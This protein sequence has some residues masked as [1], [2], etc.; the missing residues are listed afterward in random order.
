MLTVLQR[1][2]VLAGVIAAGAATGALAQED[3]TDP[4]HPEGGTA[5]T[6][7]SGAPGDMAQNDQG[8][9]PASSGMMPSGTMGA[10]MMGGMMSSG[11]MG[12]GMMGSMMQPGAMD[13]PPMMRMHR[14]M[15][16]IVFAI[17]DEDGDGAL[18]F[19]EISAIHRRI[20]DAVDADED[21]TVT[22]EEM[23]S[24]MQE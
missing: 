5:E 18:S 22:P 9:E 6:A 4:H 21:G 11:M 8:A 2:W 7:P 12:P 13:A 20:F 24:F 3:V 17:A 16:R 10:G 14:H 1:G 19:E 23:Q 15:M